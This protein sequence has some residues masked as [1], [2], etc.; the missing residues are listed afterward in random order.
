MIRAPGRGCSQ[1][2]IGG[3]GILPA[4]FGF[5]S[6]SKTAGGTPALQKAAAN[7]HATDRRALRSLSSGSEE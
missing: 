5:V 3:A 7:C 4:G 6:S 2:W 1:R